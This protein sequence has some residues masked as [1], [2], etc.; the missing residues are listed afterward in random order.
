MIAAAAW[1]TPAAARAD[2][3]RE[4]Y[5]RGVRAHTAGDHASAARA[6]AEADDLTPSNASLEAALESAMRADDVVLGAELLVRSE[7]RALD[8]AS[9][10]SVQTARKRFAGRTGRIKVECGAATTCL[11][12]IAGVAADAK[13]PIFVKVGAHTVVVQ[14][15]DL[16]FERLVDVRAD[17]VV[18]IDA[19]GEP[20]RGAEAPKPT[21]AA[22]SPAPAGGL[23][24]IWFWAGAGATVVAGAV[25]AGFGLHALSTHDRFERDGCNVG[26]SGPR[27]AD[28]DA[29]GRSGERATTITNVA[30]GT[31]AV[32]A[33]ATAAVGI[34]FV[35]WG[36]GSG[37]R[38]TGSVDR[39]GLELRMP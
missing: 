18:V 5:D 6:F 2:G 33:V 20:A 37:V 35:R 13:R 30:L 3:A 7:S 25:T 23:S 29:T 19:P 11:A 32:L 8:A 31:T 4:A 10:K 36:D 15:D 9:K 39:V 22:P 17:A 21:P 16:R 24:P 28:C 34:F 27:A 1:L 38:L 12:S 26:A 14:R